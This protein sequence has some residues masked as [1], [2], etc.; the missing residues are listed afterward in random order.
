VKHKKTDSPKK[1]AKNFKVLEKYHMNI[2]TG[3]IIDTCD[4]MRPLN[5]NAWYYPASIL[6]M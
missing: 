4:R 5:E 1:P 3:L 6:G 2:G